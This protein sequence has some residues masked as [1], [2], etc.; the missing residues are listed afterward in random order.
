MPPTFTSPDSC[1]APGNHPAQAARSGSM[2]PRSS[3]SSA[4]WWIAR[5]AKARSPPSRWP[6][7]CGMGRE[8]CV[9][10][11]Q[12]MTDSGDRLDWSR[13]K[14]HGPLPRQALH[15]RR[16]RQDQPGARA[17]GMPAAAWCPWSRAAA[18][19]TPAA[20]LDKLEALPGYTVTPRRATLVRVLREAAARS[21]APT[22]ASRRRMAPLRHPRRHR[23]GGI[24]AA[25]HRQHPLRSSPQ[26]LDALVMD[27][28]VGNGAFSTEAH[29]GRHT[30]AQPGRGGGGLLACPR[31]R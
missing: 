23:D 24:G 12:A 21:S 28:K 15:R 19:A 22:R 18:S 31:R 9:A 25:D 2:R 3:R 16:R 10:L 5:G 1:F 29:S 13:A 26:G 30:G 7:A 4:A 27:V 6:S 11:T 17:A 14:L 8:E 20:S